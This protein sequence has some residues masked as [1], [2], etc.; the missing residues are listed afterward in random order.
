MLAKAEDP[1]SREGGTL[2]GARFPEGGTGAGRGRPWKVASNWLLLGVTGADPAGRK[3]GKG[4]EAVVVVVNWEIG[5]VRGVT[6]WPGGGMMEG[7]ER[8]VGGGKQRGAL[9]EGKG[10]RKLDLRRWLG[11]GGP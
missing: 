1:V 11:S 4:E 6:K 10:V 9:A 3:G 7:W 8:G 5:E 2:G